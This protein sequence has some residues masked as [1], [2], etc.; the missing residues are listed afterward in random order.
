MNLK[1]VCTPSFTPA[2]EI[3]DMV[4]S[5]FPNLI[6]EK[7]IVR[8]KAFIG[9]VEQVWLLRELQMEID[10]SPDWKKDIVLL[11]VGGGA[12]FADMDLRGSCYTLDGFWKD[13]K[14]SS[15]PPKI[16]AFCMTLNRPWMEDPAYI[17]KAAAEGILSYFGVPKK[18][19]PACYYYPPEPIT[20][21]KRQGGSFCPKCL[22]FMEELKEPL[23]IDQL[24]NRVEELYGAVKT[25]EHLF[26]E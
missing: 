13:G 1:L 17:A 23:D 25:F 3:A 22:K 26:E 18:H 12:T 21:E 10:V 6:L 14:P 24:F 5:Y 19:D 11:I 4:Q 15:D 20:L 8:T 9:D 7:E 2:E 16:G